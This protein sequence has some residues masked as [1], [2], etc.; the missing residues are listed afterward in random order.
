MIHTIPTI[1]KIFCITYFILFF[2]NIALCIFAFNASKNTETFT[3]GDLFFVLG[4]SLLQMPLILYLTQKFNEL[5]GIVLF[6]KSTIK[7][8]EK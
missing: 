4:S 3:V 6:T 2:I 7:E 8:E 5:C 1:L